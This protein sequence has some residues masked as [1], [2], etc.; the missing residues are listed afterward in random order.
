MARARAQYVCAACGA[1]ASKWQGRCDSC[2]EWNTLQEEAPA[3]AP[4]SL[5]TGRGRRVELVPLAGVT[6]EPPRTL[7][8]I[9]GVSQGDWV[10]LFGPNQPIDAVAVAAGTIGYELLTGLSR[11]AE[12]IYIGPR[13]G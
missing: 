4:V 6:A 12:R 3:V 10:E 11:R 13:D 9:P 5:R 2:G 7:T 8:G 1:V